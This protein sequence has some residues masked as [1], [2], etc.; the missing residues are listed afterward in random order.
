MYSPMVVDKSLNLRAFVDF[1]QDKEINPLFVL[2]GNTQ[3]PLKFSE[4][5]RRAEKKILIGIDYNSLKDAKRRLELVM[6][7]LISYK[8]FVNNT[9]SNSIDTLASLEQFMSRVIFLKKFIKEDEKRILKESKKVSYTYLNQEKKLYSDLKAFV[10]ET[11]AIFSQFQKIP[12]QLQAFPDSFAQ[13]GKKLDELI[14]LLSNLKDLILARME[15]ILPRFSYSISP[16]KDFFIELASQKNLKVLISRVIDS[17]L[18][19]S[20]LSQHSVI[21]PNP[22][23]IIPGSFELFSSCKVENIGG[24]YATASEDLDVLAFGGRKLIRNF[25]LDADSILEIDRIHAQEELGINLQQFLDLCIMCGTDFT[26]K[27]PG[28]GPITALKLIKE[29]GSIENILQESKYSSSKES[30]T[31]IMNYDLARRI[32]TFDFPLEKFTHD[33]TFIQRNSLDSYERYL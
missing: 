33:L 3:D 26:G 9:Q 25:A 2:D 11:Q 29:F 13:L 27:I 23:C 22:N 20:R 1:I 31:K 24:L 19:C 16:L 5:E 21:K 6:L 30:I 10:I 15:I 18:V 14:N 12:T 7:K 4:I 32:F 28:V 8:K 17:E